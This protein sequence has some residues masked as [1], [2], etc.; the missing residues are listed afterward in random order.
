MVISTSEGCDTS[1]QLMKSS[2]LFLFI[3]LF[4]RKEAVAGLTGQN[5]QRS[6]EVHLSQTEVLAYK[7][8]FPMRGL[9]VLGRN[10]IAG[11]EM[12]AWGMVSS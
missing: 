1:S 5:P 8:S 4:L 10:A 3:C 11:A 2:L 9:G 6:V 12:E 7:G